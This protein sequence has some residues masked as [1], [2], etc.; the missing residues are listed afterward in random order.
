MTRPPPPV[1][2]RWCLACLMLFAAACGGSPP[3]I[4]L[5]FPDTFV[6]SGDAG[7]EVTSVDSVQ[8]DGACVPSCVDK[9]CGDDGCGGSCGDCDEGSTCLE[10]GGSAIC[11]EQGGCPPGERLCLDTK[12]LECDDDGVEYVVVQDCA[13]LDQACVDGECTGCVP[14]CVGK[15]CGDDSCGGSCGSCGPSMTCHEGHCLMSCDHPQCSLSEWCI[16]TVGHLA[17]CGGVINFDTDL[18]GQELGVDVPVENM[19][20]IAGVLFSTDDESST[21][22]TNSYEVHSVSMENSCASHDKWGQHWLDDVIIRFVVP[23]DG[24]LVQAATHNVS[25]YIAETWEGGIRVDFFS[26]ENPP[27]VPG[28]APFHQAWTEQSG[29]AFIQ[30]I[31]PTPIGYLAIRTESDHN[32]TFDDLG[33]GPVREY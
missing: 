5:L 23:Q 18:A 6:E 9:D 22:K 10:K 27:G 17:L 2:I 19:Y 33:F 4:L 29:T 13:A 28:A 31:A 21:V 24:G 12:V 7:D 30:H 11:I 32:F 15:D 16:D 25:L 1:A 14:D 8:P 26:P 20:G 3:D